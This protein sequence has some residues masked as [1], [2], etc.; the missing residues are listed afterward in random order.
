MTPFGYAILFSAMTVGIV[1][2]GFFYIRWEN[3]IVAR[4][5]QEWNE[6]PKNEKFTESNLT[7]LGLTNT[8]PNSDWRKS[9]YV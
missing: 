5:D 9:N 8:N 6:K 2:I 7:E 1:A 3:V 4:I